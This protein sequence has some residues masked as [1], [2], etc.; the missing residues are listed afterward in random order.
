MKEGSEEQQQSL[1]KEVVIEG[2][3]NAIMELCLRR[4]F[5]IPTAEI[6]GGLAG[7]F[8]WGPLGCSLKNKVV[9]FWRK[10]FVRG[11]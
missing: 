9:E 8:D 2:D 4:G 7:A 10:L 6:Y 11:E 3:L 5:L 1:S